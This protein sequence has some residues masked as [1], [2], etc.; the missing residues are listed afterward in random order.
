MAFKSKNNDL[1]LNALKQGILVLFSLSCI[2]F[3]VLIVSCVSTLSN[4][5]SVSS[6][7]SFV[8]AAVTS[9]L[10]PSIQITQDKPIASF[11]VAAS[12]GNSISFTDLSSNNPTSWL[13]D[14]GD[15]SSSTLQNPTH[16]YSSSGSHG[17]T[18]SVKNAGGS[19]SLSQ[20]VNS[21]QSPS[22]P[23]YRSLPTGTYITN[24]MTGGEGTLK[25]DNGWNHDAVIVLAK[26]DN[27]NYALMSVYVKSHGSF[28]ATGI[29]TGDYY[30]Y[31]ETGIDWDSTTNK[32]S[33]L[34]SHKRFD[35]IFDFT[36][37]D[38][39][40]TIN[41][42]DNGNAKITPVDNFPNP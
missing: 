6:N 28:T 36:N 9:T 24:K 21:I 15:G 32:F 25:I 40:I 11:S 1:T 3:A 41:P 37:Y 4:S 17:V 8:T 10:A 20:V 2:V 12:Y 19:D 38:W 14:F 39:N 29:D 16:V 23:L 27:P 13:W 30:I 26:T 7:T 31:S 34:M 33:T 5:S 22:T 42:V 35:D 18:L